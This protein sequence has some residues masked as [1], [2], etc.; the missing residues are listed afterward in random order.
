MCKRV[1]GTLLFVSRN[2]LAWMA[3]WAGKRICEINQGER[4]AGDAVYEPAAKTL[5]KEKGER[6]L[7]PERGA[8]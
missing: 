2:S 4:N 8:D 3:L 6:R 5:E 1:C 7:L